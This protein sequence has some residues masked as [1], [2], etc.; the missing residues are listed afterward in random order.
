M[1]KKDIYIAPHFQAF[2][3]QRDLFETL[4]TL[5]RNWFE[6][7]NERRGGI[8]GVVKHTLTNTAGKSWQTFI[9][10]Q[11]GAVY[12]SRRFPW[13]HQPT[14]RREKDFLIAMQKYGVNIPDLLYY[15]EH[16][17]DAILITSSLER[18]QDLDETLAKLGTGLEFA[19]KRQAI[20]T[21]LS[22]NLLSLHRQKLRHGCLYPKHILVS[23]VDQPQTDVRFIDIEK[24]RR[25]WLARAAMVKDLDQLC[26]H[27]EQLTADEKKQ[28]FS[29]YGALLGKKGLE[30]ARQELTRR[31]ELKKHRTPEANNPFEDAL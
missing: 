23:P 27:S 19:Q 4:W 18:Y 12:R 13:C 30:K 3:G 7:P 10:F 16:G 22:E 26:R 5:P 28:I 17:L 24:S 29:A 31:F 6:P 25:Y 8:S 2:W 11:S 1:T 9:K 20:I 15:G 21:K 14:Y